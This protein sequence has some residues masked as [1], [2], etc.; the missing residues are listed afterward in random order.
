VTNP[1]L[2]TVI[3]PESTPETP[4]E[5]VVAPLEEVEDRESELPETI[6]V[7]MDPLIEADVSVE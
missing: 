1:V 4:V 7:V 2:D 3:E 5:P 6:E